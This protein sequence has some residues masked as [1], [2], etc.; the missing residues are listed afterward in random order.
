MERRITV[1]AISLKSTFYGHNHLR[2]CMFVELHTDGCS[3]SAMFSGEC[4][5]E[6]ESL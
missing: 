4:R 6:V 5:C 1:P 2:L 3:Q